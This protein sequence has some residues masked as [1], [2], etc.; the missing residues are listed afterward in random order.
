MDA[1]TSRARKKEKT[2]QQLLEA[3]SRRLKTDGLHA[4]I[5]RIMADAELTHGAFYAYFRDKNG[6]IVESLRWAMDRTARMVAASIPADLPPAERLTRFLGFYLSPRHRQDVAEGCPVASLARDL[7]RASPELRREFAEELD[8]MIEQRRALF[9]PPGTP[10]ARDQW[11]GVMCTYVGALILSRAVAGSDHPLSDEILNA[12][13]SF[14]VGR[15][16][17]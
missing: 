11:I 7:G 3:A 10:M 16:D 6:L 15:N 9:G 17:P 8:G 13:R 5:A 1:Q 4:S 12:A 14:L 2:R